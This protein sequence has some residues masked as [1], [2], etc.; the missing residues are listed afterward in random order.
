MKPRYTLQR[1]T[2]T[3]KV[4]DTHLEINQ[5]IGCL[6]PFRR[7]TAIPLRSIASIDA[8]RMTETLVIRTIDGKERKFKIGGFGGE[9]TRVRDEILKA[10]K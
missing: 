6:L 3:I 8:K 9:A 1:P 7:G 4:W 2:F 10:M 5:Q